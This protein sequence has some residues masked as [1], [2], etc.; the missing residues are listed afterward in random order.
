ML[1]SV[2]RVQGGALVLPVVIADVKKAHSAP[3]AELKIK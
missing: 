1:K 3:F 2:I